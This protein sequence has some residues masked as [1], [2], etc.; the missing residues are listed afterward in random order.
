[1]SFN[2][3]VDLVGKSSH[4]CEQA[5]ASAESTELVK[6]LGD[7]STSPVRVGHG[8]SGRNML[9]VCLV[10]TVINHHGDKS[11]HLVSLTGIGG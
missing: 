5:I 7:N 10:L 1:M 11:R 8:T 4:A 2:H 9:A 3:G 6:S